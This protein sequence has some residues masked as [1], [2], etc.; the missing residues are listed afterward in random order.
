[1]IKE[2]TERMGIPDPDPMAILFNRG[3]NLYSIWAE[4]DAKQAVFLDIHEKYR[5]VLSMTPTEFKAM[6]RKI[7]GMQTE[8]FRDVHN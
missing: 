7:N 1:M 6:Y 8:M 2:L 3:T 4:A 5:I